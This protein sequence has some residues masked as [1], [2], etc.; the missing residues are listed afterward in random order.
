MRMQLNAN[1]RLRCEEEGE[2]NL[3]FVKRYRV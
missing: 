2:R 3:Y 1:E